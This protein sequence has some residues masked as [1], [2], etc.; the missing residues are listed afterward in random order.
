MI[1]GAKPEFSL[2]N[3]EKLDYVAARKRIYAPLYAAAV[4]RTEAFYRLWQLAR[5]ERE[6]CLWDYDGYDHLSMVRVPFPLY[7][8]GALIACALTCRSARW[9]RCL[10]TRN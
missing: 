5:I 10:T 1:S 3:G 9:W 4:V 7:L 2:W 8:F 6:L